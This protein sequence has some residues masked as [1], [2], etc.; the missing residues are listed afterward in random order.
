MSPQTQL[1]EVGSQL[2]D[3]RVDKHEEARRRKKQEIVESFKRE[4]PGVYDR[5]INMCQPTHKR[6]N[7]AITKVLGKYMEA[8]VV[9]TEKTAR[10]CIQVLKERMLEPET[11]LPLDYIQAKPLRE[12]LRDIREPKNVKLLFDVLRFEP[13]AIHRAVLFVTNNAL[14]CETPEDA[15][16]V[17]Y[18]LDRSKNS[19]YDVSTAAF[20]LSVLFG[21]ILI[22]ICLRKAD[23]LNLICQTSCLFKF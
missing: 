2:G 10:R 11:F 16:R 18:D 7:V 5:M 9:D 15:S 17:A 6:Y 21:H 23:I 3:A 4:I 20:V 19:R 13:A 22:H 12:R 1:E 14:V 8:I